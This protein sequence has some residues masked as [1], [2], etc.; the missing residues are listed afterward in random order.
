LSDKAYAGNFGCPAESATLPEGPGTVV[1]MYADPDTATGASEWIKLRVAHAVHPTVPMIQIANFPMRETDPVDGGPGDAP[2]ATRFRK[3]T[4]ADLIG[5]TVLGH[6]DLRTKSPDGGTTPGHLRKVDAIKLDIDNWK[7]WYATGTAA[8]L[9]GIFFDNCPGTIVN[10]PNDIVDDDQIRI[11]DLCAIASYV[12]APPHAVTF[13]DGETVSVPPLWLTMGN[14]GTPGVEPDVEGNE[15]VRG[16]LTHHAMDIIST[17]ESG[18]WPA[19]LP[20]PPADSSWWWTQDASPVG[21]QRI[22]AFPY[23]ISS[24]GPSTDPAQKVRHMRKY[25]GYVY[26]VPKPNEPT[27]HDCGKI[28]PRTGEPYFDEGE[29]R[30]STVPAYIDE[31]LT[32]LAR[33]LP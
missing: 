33:P 13:P 7:R 14:P 15:G 23:C 25:F 12:G 3:I 32:E 26:A 31:L 1:P 9:N 18:G 21:K 16:Y 10:P 2:K 24:L 30:W 27:G 28:D 5:I 8:G 19:S 29:P 11:E 20:E 22:A 17:V 6:V 4:E